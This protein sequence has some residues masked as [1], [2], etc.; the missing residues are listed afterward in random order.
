LTVVYNPYIVVPAATFAVAQVA[1]F[2]IAAFRGKLDFRYLYSSGGMPSVHSAIVTSLATT[3]LLIDGLDSHLFGFALVLAF[4]VMYDS[5]GVRRAAGEQAAA[6]N[7]IF[8]GL[9]R[10]KTRVEVPG[11]RV[12]LIMG[13]QPEEVLMGAVVGTVLGCLFNYSHLGVVGLFLS[14]LPGLYENIAYVV[15][16]GILVL[17]SIGT[18]L[19]IRRRKSVIMKKLGGQILTFGQTIGWLS[20]LASVLVYERANYFGW[21]VWTLF[22]LLIGVIWLASLVSHWRPRLRV[23]LEAEIEDSRKKKWIKWGRRKR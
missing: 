16:G 21:R 22:V 1:K 11:A 2:A 6:I 7:M 17:G 14:G 3:A 20:I 19:L 18:R 5:F 23:E 9:E 10:S 12:R 15:I 8:E 4:I 13:H